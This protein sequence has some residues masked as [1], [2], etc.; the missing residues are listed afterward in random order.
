MWVDGSTQGR[1]SV[2]WR[3]DRNPCDG[4]WLNRAA[5][6]RCTWLSPKLG[7]CASTGKGDHSEDREHWASIWGLGRWLCKGSAQPLASLLAS[8]GGNDET[9]SAFYF[10]KIFFLEEE[11]MVVVQQR[12][13]LSQKITCFS[14]WF[15]G[16]QTCDKRG[17]ISSNDAK[18]MEKQRF[19]EMRITYCFSTFF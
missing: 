12:N 5:P 7:G 3:K 1:R 16:L 17:N 19:G 2:R 10:C 6:S 18:P 13:A 14:L 11:T 9:P 15:F 8:S 4:Q